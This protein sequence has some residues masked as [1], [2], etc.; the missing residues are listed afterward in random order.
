MSMQID[1][2]PAT[3]GAS[4]HR[5]EIVDQIGRG[6]DEIVAGFADMRLEQMAAYAVPR[7]GASRLCGLVLRDVVTNEPVG[8]ALAVI[9]ALPLIK[10]GLAYVKFGPLWRRHG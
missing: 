7:W 9:A 3:S 5:F 4:R 2:L 8:A 1:D 10:L 6:W